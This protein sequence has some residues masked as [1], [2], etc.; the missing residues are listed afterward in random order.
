MAAYEVTHWR[1]EEKVPG[2]FLTVFISIFFSSMFIGT[3]GNYYAMNTQ[4]AWAA[5]KFVPTIGMLLGNTMI[6]VIFGIK[7]V[8]SSCIQTGDQIELYLSYGATRSEIVIPVLSKAMR[9]AL[10]PTI[11]GMRLFLSS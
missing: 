4:P 3:I 10:I 9:A 1:I 8:L 5:Y 11:N 2:M 7:S 6:G